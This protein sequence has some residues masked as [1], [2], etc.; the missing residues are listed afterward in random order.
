MS[1]KEFINLFP[2]S[3]NEY[4]EC[5]SYENSDVDFRIDL[6]IIADDQCITCGLILFSDNSSGIY[7]IKCFDYTSQEEVDVSYIPTEFIDVVSQFINVW[8]FA[9]VRREYNEG[10]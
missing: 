1:L 3:L 2:D 5:V 6:S 7:D 10:K 9:N 4:I 8:R